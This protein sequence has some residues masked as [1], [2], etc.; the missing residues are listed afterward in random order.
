M[1]N[2]QLIDAYKKA[3]EIR[4]LENLIAEN[5]K[6]GLMRCPMHLSI[7]RELVPSI[8]A[9]F[10]DKNDFAVGT[11]RS[12]GHYLGKGGNIDSFL[13]ELHGLT[14]GCS[15]GRG[16]SMHLVDNSVGFMGSTA[17]VG[18]TIPVGVGLAESQKLLSKDKLTYIF[19]GDAATE[20]R[21]FFLNL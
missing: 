1:D 4:F 15:G 9:L 14:S 2:L 19:L 21:R 17:I 11:H 8:L 20:E 16:G 10:Q 12:H 5:Y 6:D 3:Y 13:D 7:G 18:N